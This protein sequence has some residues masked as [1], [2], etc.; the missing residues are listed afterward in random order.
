MGH[1]PNKPVNEGL[2]IDR[3]P[4]LGEKLGSSDAEPQ[5]TVSEPVVA[6]VLIQAA[7]DLRFG[8]VADD[9]DVGARRER[10]EGSWGASEG[11]R[12]LL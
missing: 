1:C 12:T 7:T 10:E 5:E 8:D 2:E 11:D 3:R 9:R 4:A 6:L